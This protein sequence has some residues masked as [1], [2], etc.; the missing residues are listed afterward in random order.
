LAREE[1]D[2]I[3]CGRLG[4]YKYYNMDQAVGAALSVF[5]KRINKTDRRKL[6]RVRQIEFTA[7]VSTQTG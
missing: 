7:G 4:D 2:V 6:H 1:E 3:F 5:E